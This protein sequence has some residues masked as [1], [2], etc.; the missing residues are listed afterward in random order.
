MLGG[1]ER[2]E[3]CGEG[4]QC[5]AMARN[6]ETPISFSMTAAAGMCLTRPAPGIVEGKKV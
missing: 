3:G 6:V 4:G 5:Q 2:Q 1:G